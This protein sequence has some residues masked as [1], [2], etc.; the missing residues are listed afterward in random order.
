MEIACPNCGQMLHIREGLVNPRCRC[1]AC[2]YEFR[3][4]ELG[5]TPL[6]PGRDAAPPSRS[7]PS[8]TVPPAPTVPAVPPLRELPSSL[9]QQPW[10]SERDRPPPTMARPPVIVPKPVKPSNKAGW[11][12]LIFVGLIVAKVVFRLVNQHWHRQPQPP[13]NEIRAPIPAGAIWHLPG[14]Q[15]RSSAASVESGRQR[16]S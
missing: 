11:G 9:E 6:S 14:T 16:P 7:L 2:R 4:S 15:A 1:P 3:A 12:T 10:G 13:R 5:P 8:A